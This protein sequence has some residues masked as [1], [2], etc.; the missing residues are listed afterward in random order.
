VVEA[1]FILSRISGTWASVS[2]A[3][4]LESIY[5]IIMVFFKL[6][7]FGVGVDEAGTQY[8]SELL[9]LGIV[10]G[11]T[12]AIIRKGRT[13]FWTAVGLLLILTREFS[14]AEIFSHHESEQ[15]ENKNIVSGDEVN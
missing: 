13:F 5:R 11:I 15:N 2:N 10:V 8:V 9:G 7:P 1:W 4:I 6:I 12:L 14:L 3:F